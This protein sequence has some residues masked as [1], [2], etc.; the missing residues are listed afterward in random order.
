MLTSSLPVNKDRALTLLG[1]LQTQSAQSQQTI[2]ELSL[3]KAMVEAS[4]NPMSCINL[5]TG[6]YEIVNKAYLK[7]HG[8]SKEDIIG[9]T[10]QEFWAKDNVW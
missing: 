7:A 9:K 5:K 4:Q 6:K 8:I 2:T 3:Y 1:Q 10:I